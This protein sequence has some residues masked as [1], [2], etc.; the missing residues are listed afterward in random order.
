MLHLGKCVYCGNDRLKLFYTYTKN[1]YFV[2]CLYCFRNTAK[3]DTPEEA[4]ALYEK[5][6]TTAY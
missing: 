6:N 5:K 1:K 3:T 2:A 4:I